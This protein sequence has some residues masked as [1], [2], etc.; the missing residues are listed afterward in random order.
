MAT[1]ANLA[2]GANGSELAAPQELLQ[3][4]SATLE[5][6]TQD[7]VSEKILNDLSHWLCHPD[8]GDVDKVNL[9]AYT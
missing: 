9:V 4:A 6:P 3:W 8:L 7:P 2:T 5:R 1:L